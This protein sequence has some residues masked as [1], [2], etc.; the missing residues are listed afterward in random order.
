LDALSV[1]RVEHFVHVRE[2]IGGVTILRSPAIVKSGQCPAAGLHFDLG[3][4]S[5]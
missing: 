4:C 1:A 5:S 3:F 2:P